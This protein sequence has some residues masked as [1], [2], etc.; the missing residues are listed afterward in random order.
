MERGRGG[1]HHGRMET[2]GMG[3]AA[4]G[5]RRAKRG[6]APMA[7]GGRGREARGDGSVRG[8]MREGSWARGLQLRGCA[9]WTPKGRSGDCSCEEEEQWAGR[10]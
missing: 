5:G 9:T 4:S 10:H 1:A 8:G 6:K 7:R 3:D 2:N